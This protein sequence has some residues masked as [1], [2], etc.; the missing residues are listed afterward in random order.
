MRI[1]CRAPR[2]YAFVIRNVEGSAGTVM[3]S[4]AGSE[5][6]RAERDYVLKGLV[7]TQVAHSQPV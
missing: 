4:A 6:S 7:A 3:L 1:A 5:P 2:S